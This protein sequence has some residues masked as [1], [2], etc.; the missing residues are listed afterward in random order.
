MTDG[1][2]SVFRSSVRRPALVAAIA[3]ACLGQ[4]SPAVA[5]DV[6]EKL[7]AALEAHGCTDLTD[8]ADA[9]R[10]AERLAPWSPAIR[11][12]LAALIGKTSIYELPDSKT[13]EIDKLLAPVEA[14]VIIDLEKHGRA[15][16]DVMRVQAARA[17]N[18]IGNTPPP[19]SLNYI[20]IGQSL[21]VALGC[22][23][24]AITGTV[25]PDTAAAWER[26]RPGQ[27]ALADLV[28]EGPQWLLALAELAVIGRPAC[29]GSSLGPPGKGLPVK[30]LAALSA[31]AFEYFIQQGAWDPS[32][33]EAQYRDH[34]PRRHASEAHIRRAFAVYATAVETAAPAPELLADIERSWADRGF[35][36]TL[37]GADDPA[38]FV[39][40]G[41]M[42]YG[43]GQ[44]ASLAAQLP[45][46]TKFGFA[47]ALLLPNDHV[48]LTSRWAYRLLQ[49]AF[50]TLR[51]KRK[52]GK[53][54]EEGSPY[55][56]E[57]L[58]TVA[59]LLG[60]METRGVGTEKHPEKAARW[61]L[62]GGYRPAAS[63]YQPNL[64]E[65]DRLELVRDLLQAMP[66]QRT[67]STVTA[68]AADAPKAQGPRFAEAPIEVQ[69]PL[70]IQEFI[71]GIELA[72][73]Y[74]S[75]EGARA[76]VH[77]EATSK[78]KFALATLLIEGHG[79]TGKH[80][81][82]GV[83]L[84]A[85]AAEAGDTAATVRLA[86]AYEFGL[87]VAID[88]D[89]A[90]VLYEKAA[91]AGQPLAHLARARAY[92]YGDGGAEPNLELAD[93]HYRAAVAKLLPVARG[94]EQRDNPSTKEEAGRLEEFWPETF[95]QE[96]Q[97]QLR[98][99]ALLQTDITR[100][101][102]YFSGP[103]GTKLLDEI[104]AADPHAAVELGRMFLC[105]ECGT[106]VR[107]DKAAYW[108]N[109]GAKLGNSASTYWLVRLVSLM[110]DLGQGLGEIDKLIRSTFTKEHWYAHEIAYFRIANTD[111][112]FAP[113]ALKQHL[114]NR[115]SADFD[116]ECTKAAHRMAIGAVAPE[117]VAPGFELLAE[118]AERKDLADYLSSGLAS[119]RIDALLFY[120]NFGEARELLVNSG[121][122]TE[123]DARRHTFSRLVLTLAEASDAQIAAEF[124]DVLRILAAKGDE[125][126]RVFKQVLE[127]RG[128]VRAEPPRIDLE[129]ARTTFR[130]QLEIGANSQGLVNASRT[131]SQALARS[132][133][134]QQALAYE[135]V[136]L[137]VQSELA[138]IGQV[139]TG[140]LPYKL[141]H[142]C[143]L[144]RSSERVQKLGFADVATVLAKEAVNTLQEVRQALAGL[145]QRL[146][147]CFASLTADQYR[148]LF[149]LFMSQ[150]RIGEAEAVNRMMKDA[151]AYE[152]VGLDQAY[153]NRAFD[154]LPL[155]ALEGEV[156][157]R[158]LAMRPVLS[159]RTARYHALRLRRQGGSITDG[160]K[161]ELEALEAE[162][163]VQDT[164]FQNQAKSLGDAIASLADVPRR[165]AEEARMLD[166][167]EPIKGL[168]RQRG[169]EHA[170]ALHFVVMPDRMHAILTTGT[171][172]TGYTWER[173]GDEPFSEAALNRKIDQLRAAV[174]RRSRDADAIGTELYKLLFQ[175]SGFDRELKSVGARKLLLSLDRRLRYLPFAALRSD[176]GWL[177]ESFT[178]SMLTEAH[179]TGAGSKAQPARV[180][181]FG[182]TRA[183]GGFDALPHVDAEIRSIVRRDGKSDI[184]ILSGEAKLDGAFSR[185]AFQDGLL[186]KPGT[187]ARGLVV[188]VA[189][190]FQ[191]GETDAKSFL[192]L[193]D[194]T[195]LPVKDLKDQST[196]YDFGDVDLLTLSACATAYA[197]AKPAHGEDLEA[198]AAVVQRKGVGS[199]LAT[200]W[201]VADTATA[202]FMERFYRLAVEQKLSWSE[203]LARTQREFIA[204]DTRKRSDPFY[205]ASF[206]LLGGDI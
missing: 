56:D 70:N 5:R 26:V 67:S 28:K 41:K 13:A 11:K 191:F 103:L 47:R 120:G 152:Y 98:N 140:P 134:K 127:E 77:R 149:G 89:K 167:L 203:A 182:T 172:Q 23:I 73:A 52:A 162:I 166:R 38:D 27:R 96:L 114:A 76:L 194:G 33:N 83:A 124:V 118:W 106:A 109:R 170:A 91:D 177:V 158:A 78:T 138:R 49:E 82:L 111:K 10:Q 110:P 131:L 183:V 123:F 99:L 44:H 179:R 192:L 57:I 153:V 175:Q 39:P 169:D 168:L 85:E 6:P 12:S 160:E 66:G 164:A 25:T 206:V 187:A 156:L 105:A 107:P 188:H 130:R 84:M 180:A 155:N 133:E 87:G 173:L 58:R 72:D 189:S 135:L 37:D 204:S 139:E 176:S 18:L 101:G 102:P 30:A 196:V 4:H 115:C 117:F 195:R 7:A 136:A 193:G 60:W 161:L 32:A 104:V 112:K 190:H 128:S 92:E 71:S 31:S 95:S 65:Q 1:I 157:K 80:V 113:A 64:S 200:Q 97:W 9:L 108:F 147:S 79:R 42:L 55:E 59:M 185:A 184:G 126:A 75:H 197:A 174:E 20:G 21:L 178:L 142:A 19:S 86:H 61:L 69:A 16:C 35:I 116:D 119:A 205:W 50:A 129:Q 53:S 94:E 151:E 171:G 143:Q 122:S 132:G 201:P 125:R 40:I 100:Q 145:P 186:R 2:R 68:A 62:D 199:V 181:A 43:R 74:V 63:L 54:E 36:L 150:G 29:D 45:I 141:I 46:A 81:E 146:R 88:R 90:N 93:K 163:R 3:L 144:A 8:P 137:N 17:G 48:Q 154:K 24:K 34:D 159:A 22:P 51:D 198:F 15:A 148:L 202:A 165:R 14:R 121:P